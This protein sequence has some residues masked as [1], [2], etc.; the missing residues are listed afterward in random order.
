LQHLLDFSEHR[1]NVEIIKLRLDGGKLGVS[2]GPG[3]FSQAMS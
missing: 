3:A 1:I 2:S